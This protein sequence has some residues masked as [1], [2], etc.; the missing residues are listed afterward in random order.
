MRCRN[1]QSEIADNALICYKCGTATTEAKFQPPAPRRA[2]PNALI[3]TLV[4]L[5]LL[6]AA[7][8]ADFIS[9]SGDAPHLA[10][11]AVLAAVVIVGLR[12]WA[13]RQR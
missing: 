5:V 1:C 9:S 11:W 10:T 13:R 8:Y 4:A 12:A 3:V 7:A 2:S 6:A